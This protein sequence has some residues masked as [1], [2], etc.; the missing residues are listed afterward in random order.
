MTDKKTIALQ[1]CWRPPPDCG[2]PVGC[3]ATSYT[4]TAEFFEQECLAEFLQMSTDPV[5]DGALY[6]IEREESM[7]GLVGAAVMV[8]VLHCAGER[9]LRWDLIPARVDSGIFHPKVCLLVWDRCVRLI[10][11]SANLTS[12][13]Y[14]RNQEVVGVLDFTEGCGLPAETLDEALQALEGMLDYAQ[15]GEG[16]TARRR[17]RAVIQEARKRRHFAES[18]VNADLRIAPLFVFPGD[19]RSLFH[20][21]GQH[22]GD[23]SIDAA[24]V[25]SPF[26]DQEEHI[27]GRT[28]RGLMELTVP[29]SKITWQTTSKEDA[30]AGDYVFAM[31]EATR[32][33]PKEAGYEVAFQHMPEDVEAGKDVVI[34]PL[35]AKALWLQ[36]PEVS[37]ML[38]GSSNFTHRGTGVTG[39]SNVEANLLYRFNSHVRGAHRALCRSWLDG[40]PVG[41]SHVRFMPPKPEEDAEEERDEIMALPPGFVDASLSAFQGQWRL[42]LQLGA[43]LPES[44]CVQLMHVDKPA[45]TQQRWL[46][47]GKPEEKL[48]DW[49][50]TRL[51]SQ[52]LVSWQGEDAE[53]RAYWP[54]TVESIGAL[55]APAEL[56]KLNLDRLIEIL[57]SGVSLKHALMRYL[58]RQDAN[59]TVEAVMQPELDPHSRVDTR[60]FLLNR[61]RRISRAFAGLRS[62]LEKPVLTDE[63]LDWRLYGPIGVTALAQAIQQHAQTQEE[64]AFLLAELILELTRVEYQEADGCLDA[65]AVYGRIGEVVRS[66]RQ[67][68]DAIKGL[69]AELRQYCRAVL[70]EVRE[71]VA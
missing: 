70:T 53:C 2:E 13:G 45:Y 6:L 27:A 52:L 30:D 15:V 71:G 24:Y 54:V 4:F 32:T 58:Q 39:Y 55:P 28:I 3:L 26:F 10:V 29:G 43:V 64:R 34:R 19:D 25:I 31:P 51:P 60:E 44:W 69:P 40:R 42:R 68:L 46:R 18:S 36:G 56:S 11:S 35:H 57:S 50:A 33:V 62:R 37:S 59:A 5:E 49:G 47:D 8:D 48:L 17:W 7:A 12:D 67:D 65:V 9:S 23:Q 41:L 61:T 20:Q 63:A 16:S 14:R 38:I 21:L 66:L 1:A 22:L